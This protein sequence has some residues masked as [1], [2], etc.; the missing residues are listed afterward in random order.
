MSIVIYSTATNLKEGIMKIKGKIILYLSIVVFVL[1]LSTVL[2]AEGYKDVKGVKL[3]DGT[4]I[5]GRVIETNVYKVII[6]QK[7][8]KIVPLK[9]DDVSYFLKDEDAESYQ[10]VEKSAYPVQGDIKQAQ[11]VSPAQNEIKQEASAS[12]VRGGGFY[13]GVGGNYAFENFDIDNDIDVNID[14]SWGV[15]AR[16]GYQFNRLFSVEF[17]YDYLAEF[18]GSKTIS[19]MGDTIKYEAEVELMTFMIAGK[20]SPNIGSEIVR[21]YITVGAGIMHGSSDE[22]VSVTGWYPD[23]SVSTTD[24]GPCAKIGVGID[25]SATKNVSIGIEGSYVMGFD[26]MDN[27]RYVNLNLGVAY[28]F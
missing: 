23:L 15:N 26:T 24:D 1:S 16:V 20:F 18:S 9:F 11:S 2:F 14:N 5:Y 6:E 7:D 28:H 3:N 4:V 12:P 17:V 10:R 13:V 22:T 8:G 19:D 27:I 25:F 21:P